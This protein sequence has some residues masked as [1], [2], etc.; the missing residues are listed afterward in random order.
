MEIG[1]TIYMKPIG[2]AARFNRDI[3]ECTISK[4]GRKFFEVNEIPRSR[5]HIDNL[6]HDGGDYNPDYK[7][8]LSLKDIEDE[9][10]AGRLY[11]EIKTIWFDGYTNSIPLHKL[12]EIK[13]ILDKKIL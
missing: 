12:I 13:E 6:L 5:F 2:N 3:K 9:D 4:I 1:Q 7:G 10:E 8:Y 11:R